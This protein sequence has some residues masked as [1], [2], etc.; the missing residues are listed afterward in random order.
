MKTQVA[1]TAHGH[2]EGAM[3]EHFKPHRISG[4]TANVL[5]FN[6][7]RYLANLVHRQ[8]A[9]QHGNIHP[10]R[11]E[12]ECLNVGNVELCGCMNLHSFGPGVLKHSYIRSDDGIHTRSHGG[13]HSFAHGL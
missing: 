8:L 11:P 3:G 10:T 1:L 12:A 7:L 9:R 5:Y 13:V 2:A 4:G 6:G